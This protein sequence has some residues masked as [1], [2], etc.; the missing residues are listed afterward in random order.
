MTNNSEYFSSYHTNFSSEYSFL[1]KKER[2][3]SQFI[4][5]QNHSLL[6]LVV[7]NFSMFKLIFLYKRFLFDRSGKRFVQ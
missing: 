5:L 3:G 4:S 2:G 7:C 1:Q 6:N